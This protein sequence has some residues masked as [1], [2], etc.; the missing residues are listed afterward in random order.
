M[1]QEE[2]KEIFAKTDSL[3]DKDSSE[4]KNTTLVNSITR[5]ALNR[6]TDPLQESLSDA[7]HLDKDTKEKYIHLAKVYTQDMQKNIFRDQFELNKLYPDTTIDEW[8]DFLSD[9][10]VSTYIAKHKRTLL[11]SAAESNLANPIGK[12][13]RDNLQLIKNI[14]EEEQAEA[15]KNICIIR[16]PDIYD[17]EENI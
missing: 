4:Y 11:K 17:E 9:R 3:F 10:I 1:T 13:K 15:N 5:E 2:L 16:I 6:Q 12:N 8:N 14:E 7:T